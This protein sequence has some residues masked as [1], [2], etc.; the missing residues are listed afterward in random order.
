[1]ETVPAQ[2]RFIAINSHS[3]TAV[4]GHDVREIRRKGNLGFLWPWKCY[5]HMLR[6]MSEQKAPKIAK[7]P[8]LAADV[9]LLVTAGFI[10]L[11]AAAPLGVAPVVMLA[12]CVLVGG[13]VCVAPFIMEYQGNAKLAE[14]KN[15]SSA[16]EQIENVRSVANQ[17]S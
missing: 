4:T 9:L 12:L 17:I 8:F 13:V 16:V 2:S 6:D 1:M 15:F 5:F 7:W 3:H 11:N 10:A 14:Y